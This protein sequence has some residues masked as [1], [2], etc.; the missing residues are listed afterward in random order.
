MQLFPL[1]LFCEATELFYDIYTVESIVKSPDPRKADEILDC[2]I[3]LRECV[4]RNLARAAK[5]GRKVLTDILSCKNLK[6]R[7]FYHKSCLIEWIVEQADKNIL[8]C[9]ICQEVTSINVTSLVKE[10]IFLILEGRASFYPEFVD[11]VYRILKSNIFNFLIP[12]VSFDNNIEILGNSIKRLEGLKDSSYEMSSLLEKCIDSKKV[13]K[14]EAMDDF[15]HVYN[16]LKNPCCTLDAL[17]EAVKKYATIETKHEQII[18]FLLLNFF[19]KN[20][21]AEFISTLKPY[22][23]ISPYYWRIIKVVFNRI[24]SVCVNIEEAEDLVNE[25]LCS[26]AWWIIDEISKPLLKRIPLIPLI[27]RKITSSLAWIESEQ[28][29]L[30]FTKSIISCA[31][32][33]DFRK[34]KSFLIRMIDKCFAANIQSL[35]NHEYIPKNQFMIDFL[36]D[37]YRSSQQRGTTVEEYPWFVYDFICAKILEETPKLECFYYNIC[38]NV[39]EKEARNKAAGIKEYYFMNVM[40]DNN[41]LRAIESERIME[42]LVADAKCE[43]ISMRLRHCLSR[44]NAKKLYKIVKARM[45]KRS[46]ETLFNMLAKQDETL[47]Y[48]NYTYLRRYITAEQKYNKI[49][50]WVSIPKKE[51]ESFC[52]HCIMKGDYTKIAPLIFGCRNMDII[53]MLNEEAVEKIISSSDFFAQ[54][55]ILR[56]F[57][58][59]TGKS[60]LFVRHHF[61][62]IFEMGCKKYADISSARVLLLLKHLNFIGFNG[63]NSFKKYKHIFKYLAQRA[64][65]FYLLNTGRDIF[66]TQFNCSLALYIAKLIKQSNTFFASKNVD[67]NNYKKCF[68]KWETD[69]FKLANRSSESWGLQSADTWC[70]KIDAQDNCSKNWNPYEELEESG[71]HLI[72]S[73]KKYDSR[74]QSFTNN[75]TAFMPRQVVDKIKEKLVEKMKQ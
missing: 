49:G 15:K 68:D 60:S 38:C 69:I 47:N 36:A 19:S 35:E 66:S 11:L 22:S 23:G 10:E 24:E 14:N 75:L 29:C 62:Q 44:D 51:I 21:P 8:K 6:N 13:Y 32:H 3:C 31:K 27:E 53:K 41:H 25:A 37:F 12:E 40:L 67:L 43:H 46:A 17:T 70:E 54:L 28:K 57:F 61:I 48:K 5:E 58:E 4:G 64:D 63:S 55:P 73:L 52:V 42:V 56:H 59:Q 7:H 39:V 30:A 65:A 72:H 33:S 2:A 16:I 71:M 20:R 50:L 9:P 74:S 26:E 34:I 45:E 18:M 1:F